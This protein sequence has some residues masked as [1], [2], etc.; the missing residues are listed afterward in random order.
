MIRQLISDI[1]DG[2]L[3]V[4]AILSVFGITIGTT[5][6]ITSALSLGPLQTIGVALV[7]TV[8]GFVLTAFFLGPIFVLLD[9]RDAVRRRH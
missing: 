7:A 8:L 1:F 5:A 4:V 2:L 3:Q 6:G 9:I